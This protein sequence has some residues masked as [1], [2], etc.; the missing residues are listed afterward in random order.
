M[1]KKETRKVELNIEI[2]NLYKRTG[3]NKNMPLRTTLHTG[4]L[5]NSLASSFKGHAANHYKN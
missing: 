3:A 2:A 5:N 1:K 4:T